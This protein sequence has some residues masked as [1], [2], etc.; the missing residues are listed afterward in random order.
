MQENTQE[1]SMETTTATE[2]QVSPCNDTK[3][4]GTS[5]TRQLEK[6]EE[7][8]TTKSASPART[9]HAEMHYDSSHEDSTPLHIHDCDER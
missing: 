3:Q 7:S 4:S 8:R 6:Q 9:S 5:T 2:M 1:S